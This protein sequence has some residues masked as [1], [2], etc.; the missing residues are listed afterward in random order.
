MQLRLNIHNPC[1][2][3]MIITYKH[4]QRLCSD[5]ILMIV[6]F[7]NVHSSASNYT[8]LV[9][10]EMIQIRK[11][12]CIYHASHAIIALQNANL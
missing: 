9:C 6:P 3:R 4:I 11:R 7:Q 10:R 5:N 12:S 1:H 2:P 8:K